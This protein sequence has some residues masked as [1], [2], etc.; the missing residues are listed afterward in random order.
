[1]PGVAPDSVLQLSLGA[2]PRVHEDA[3]QRVL[4]HFDG[5]PGFSANARCV[6]AVELVLEEWLTNAF[7]HG[8]ARTV[9]LTAGCDAG[10]EL[11][12]TFEDDGVPFDP[13]SLQAQPRPASLDQAAPSGLGLLLIGH[14]ASRWQ[15]TARAEGN[16]LQVWIALPA[17]G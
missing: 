3:R 17:P 14:Y 2:D 10:C 12:L 4:A 6:Y 11:T 8:G 15:H 7:R 5:L 13:T 16:R 9:V 1:M